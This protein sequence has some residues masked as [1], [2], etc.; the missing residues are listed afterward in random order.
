[1]LTLSRKSSEECQRRLSRERAVHSE[2][3]AE[4]EFEIINL[5]VENQNV[6]KENVLSIADRWSTK[7]GDEE[8]HP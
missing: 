6:N 2:N 3:E 7:R 8:Y 4:L 5:S 1:M